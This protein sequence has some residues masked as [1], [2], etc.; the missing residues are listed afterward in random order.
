M[1]ENQLPP[2]EVKDSEM[3]DIEWEPE[4]MKRR[5]LLT[6]SFWTLTGLMT[7]AVTGVGARFLAGDAFASTKTQW[8]RL[9]NLD[10]LS[11]GQMHRVTYTIRV[12]DAWQNIEQAGTAFVDSQTGGEVVVFDATC[13][14]LSCI[15]RWKEDVQTFACPCHAGFFDRNGDVLDGPPPSPLRRLATKTE[16]GALWV[17]I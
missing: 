4:A 1:K 17:E 2:S 16:D 8:V 6:A 12:K 15:V 10:E 5:R 13:T 11:A 14:H 7:A 3:K 9:M